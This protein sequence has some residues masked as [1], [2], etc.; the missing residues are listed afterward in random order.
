MKLNDLF[1]AYIKDMQRRGVKSIKR[2]QQFY[3]NDIRKVLGDREVSDI[4][5]GDIASLLFDITDRSPYTS[6]KCL[7]PQG[8]V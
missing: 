8:Y 3:D 6:N 1:G 4:I 2:T 7:Y 5:R